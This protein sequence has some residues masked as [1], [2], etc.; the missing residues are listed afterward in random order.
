MPLPKAGDP[1]GFSAVRGGELVEADAPAAPSAEAREAVAEGPP[2]LRGERTSLVSPVT[3]LPDGAAE[4]ARVVERRP[5]K[6]LHPAEFRARCD[7]I[8]DRFAVGGGDALRYEALAAVMASAGRPLEEH[9]AYEGLCRR[10]GCDPLVGLSRRDLHTFFEKAPQAV[11]DGA[12]RSLEP[13]GGMIRRGAEAMPQT[14]HE[15]PVNYFLFEDDKQFAILHV[16]VNAHLYYGAADFV[17]R[18]SVRAYFGTNR[19]ELQICA[20]GSYGAK[21]MYL[22]KLV[23]QPLSADVVSED[24]Q[25]HL[26]ETAGRFGSQRVTVKLMKSQPGKRWYKVGHSK[27]VSGNNQ[28]V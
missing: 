14:L 25:L 16:E 2:P 8:F 11:W 10:L 17:T 26:E 27:V 5:I 24:C 6:G 18:D 22:W 13:Y 9:A 21:E 4:A 15:R 28:K 23:V 12:Y 7:L 20:P 1:Q 3:E 19:M